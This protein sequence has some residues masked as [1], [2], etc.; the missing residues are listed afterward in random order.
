[1]GEREFTT[2][3]TEITE[4]KKRKREK[5]QDG[6]RRMGRFLPRITRIFTE[7]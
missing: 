5:R 3:P 1:L 2:E 6:M 7:E 4:K